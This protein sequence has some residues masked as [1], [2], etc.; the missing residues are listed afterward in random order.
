MR[1]VSNVSRAF[2]AAAALA[3]L[4]AGVQ[5]QTLGCEVGV[6]NGG[7]IPAS[8]TGGGGTFPTILPGNASVFSLTVLSLP[9]GS[10]VVT[11]VKLKGLTHSWINDVHFVLTDPAG[12][13]H[14]LFVRRAGSCD[15]NGDYTIVSPCTGGLAY[16]ATCSGATILTPGSYD[17]FFGTWPSGTN[18]IVNTPLSS[19]AAATGV[20][21]L[22]VYD[23]A[24][25]DTGALTTF[26]VCFGTPVPPTAPSASPVLTAPSNGAVAANPVTLTWNAV[27]CATTYDVDLDGVVTNVASTT[28]GAPVLAPGVHTWSVRA[29]NASGSSAYATPFTFTVP[30]PPPASTCVT[31]GLGAGPVPASGTGGTGSTWPTVLPGTP[32]TNTYNVT[33]P[34]G[35]TQIVKVE[36]NFG[37]EHTFVGDLQV[38][39]TDPTGGMHN[40]LH[41]FGFTTAGFGSG[42]DLN[43]AYSFYQSAGLSLPA[44][45]PGSGDVLPGDYLQNFGTWNS[46]DLGIFNTPLSAIPIANG[47]WTLTVYD[48]AAG[49]VGALADWQLCFDSGPSGPTTY[50]TAGTTTNGCNAAITGTAQPSASLA[51]PCVL[52]VANVEGQKQGLI[53]YGVNNSGFTPSSWGT[54]STSFLCVKSP[55][56]RTGTQ[57]SGGTAGG[58]AGSFTLDW[59][60]YQAANPGAL[61]NPF[62]TGSKV[63][64]Q[65][66][67][68]DPPAPK[69]TNLSDALEMTVQP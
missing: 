44:T 52:N 64:A 54:G 38:V 45:C 56:Q 37:T 22:T 5:A 35:A 41:R 43:G 26:D 42:C 50:C 4:T 48:W 61:G 49:D 25:G 53:F 57:T 16:P 67:F 46:G 1:L 36:L 69:T 62:L 55:N 24:G 40:V 29:V 20:W 63:Y 65:A 3:V 27:D 32:Y 39:L 68:R 9:P 8:G 10:T 23:W 34:A 31:N 58:C 59:N 11:E 15:F 51:N 13:N 33:L 14:N 19:I 6:A 60:A 30:T 12:T 17:Q 66:W 21:T 2:G 7:L 28:F 18:S 47:N